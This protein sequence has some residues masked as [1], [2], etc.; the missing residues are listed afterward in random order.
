MDTV[1]YDYVTVIS[2][3]NVRH[4]RTK[5]VSNDEHLND[6]GSVNAQMVNRIAS[7]LDNLQR[8]IRLPSRYTEAG[9]L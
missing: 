9:R 1:T 4:Q 3:S 5:F 2:D 6:W 8:F 7:R